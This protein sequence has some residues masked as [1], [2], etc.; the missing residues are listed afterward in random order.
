MA[1]L[2]NMAHLL[3]GLTPTDNR[4]I[5]PIIEIIDNMSA[6]IIGQKYDATSTKGGNGFFR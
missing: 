1:H 6:V 3:V 2:L 5:D 4:R